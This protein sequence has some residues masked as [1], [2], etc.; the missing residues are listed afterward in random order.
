MRTQ[1]NPHSGP[2]S[3]RHSRLVSFSIGCSQE[4][5]TW[6]LCI[7]EVVWKYILSAITNENSNLVFYKIYW[8]PRVLFKARGIALCHSWDWSL[9]TALK[10]SWEYVGR[11]LSLFPRMPLP[12]PNPMQVNLFPDSEGSPCVNT[13]LRLCLNRSSIYL[14]TYLHSLR[15]YSSGRKWVKLEGGHL[16][17]CV[18]AKGNIRMELTKEAKYCSPRVPTEFCRLQ[19]SPS[20]SSYIIVQDSCAGWKCMWPARGQK[21]HFQFLK[22]GQH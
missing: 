14:K 13:Y 18:L 8:W 6:V 4:P 7:S 19:L 22:W 10:S 5:N 15:L 3:N 17:E 1:L 20:F 16:S 2:M 9:K 21:L 11:I 12:S